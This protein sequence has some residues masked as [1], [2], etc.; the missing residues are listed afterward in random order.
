MNIIKQMEQ[1][2]AIRLVNDYKIAKLMQAKKEQPFNAGIDEAITYFKE[3]SA[4][5]NAAYNTLI[6]EK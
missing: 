5:I 2:Q 1:L 4:R 6:G 3:Y